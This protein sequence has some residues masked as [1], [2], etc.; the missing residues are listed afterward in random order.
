LAG[1]QGCK[2]T[3]V[4]AVRAMIQSCSTG[5]WEIDFSLA[6]V[7]AVKAIAIAVSIARGKA[8]MILQGS[9]KKRLIQHSMFSSCACKK[10]KQRLS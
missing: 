1:D 7:S 6:R 10:L 4:L 3:R 9:S 5:E 2:L 8:K